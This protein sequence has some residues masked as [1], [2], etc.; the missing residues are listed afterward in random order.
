MTDDR[1]YVVC[2]R[3]ENCLL[4]Y[5]RDCDR[6]V[7]VPDDHIGDRLFDHLA[8]LC[9]PCATARAIARARELVRLADGRRR[10]DPS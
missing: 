7:W 4:D 2:R 3:V 9:P 8:I 5:C 1:P 10:L 6:S